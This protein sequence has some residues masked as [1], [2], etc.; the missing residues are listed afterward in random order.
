MATN[1]TENLR[2]TMLMLQNLQA[3]INILHKMIEVVDKNLQNQINSLVGLE[4]AK[5]KDR[6]GLKELHKQAEVPE[7][8]DWEA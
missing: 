3:Q 8:D 1:E 5:A 6:S 2:E 4:I 7:K